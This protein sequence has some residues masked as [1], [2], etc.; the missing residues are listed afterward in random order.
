M[1]AKD[2]KPK[3]R[4]TVEQ[5]EARRL[6]AGLWSFVAPTEI[7]SHLTSFVRAEDYKLATLDATAIRNQ[8]ALAPADLTP[9]GATADNSIISV[10]RPDGTLERFSIFVSSIMAPEL[11]A[12]FPEIQTY[13]GQ[14]IDN[15]ASTIR[16]DMTPQGFHAQVISPGGTYYVDPFSNVPSDFY[17]VYSKGTTKIDTGF[18]ELESQ[19]GE[20]KGD[21]YSGSGT[22]SN[23][24]SIQSRS[25]THLRKY[26]LA[27][28]A[29]G[30]YTAFHG[31][32]V[33]LGQA[34]IVTAVN[35]V[36]E[37][38]Q[39]ELSITFQ[40]VANN[41]QLVFTNAGTDGYTNN[42]GGAMLG[43]NQT[44]LDSI[45][46]NSNY[47][48]GHVFSTGGGG[49][50]LLG[51]VG[52]N[53]VKA[54]GVTGLPAPIG[55]AFYVDYVAH[56]MGHQFGGNHTFNS[57]AGSCTGNRN[58]STA[59]EPG[60]GTTIQAYAGIC[61]GDDLQGNSD[62]YFHFASLD[63]FVA[64]VDKVIPNVG[65]R[66]ITGN[67]IPLINA[68][69]DY[70]I[71]ARTPFVLT[72]V[73]S[74]ADAFDSLTYD[75]QQSDL[76][77]TQPITAPDNGQSP[78]FR[79]WTPSASP[80]RTFP[81]LSDL[82]NNTTAKGERLPTTTRQL[83]F[84][85]V[86][87]DNRI[88]GGA[89]DDDSMRI[90][91][92]DTGA[93][94]AVVTP[95]TNVSWEGLTFQKVDWDV[96]GTTSNGINASSVNI[97]VSTDGGLSYPFAVA[98]G[99]ANNGSAIVRIPNAPTTKARVRV[100]AASNIFFDIS[101]VN[102]TIT[103]ATKVIDINLGPSVTFVENSNPI[104]V[105][106]A[107][108]VTETNVPGYAGGVLTLAITTGFQNGDILDVANQGSGAGEISINGS[109]VAFG[110]IVVGTY[111]GP[112]QSIKVTLNSAA[113]ASALQKLVARV[114]FVHTTDD[115]SPNARGVTAFLDNGVNGA[116][117]LATVVVNV[118][119]VNDSPRSGNASL[120]TINEDTKNPAGSSIAT[121]V[122]PSFQD[123][124]RGSSL[125]GIAITS[126][127]SSSTTGQWQYSIDAVA[128]LP[129]GNVTPA[130]GLA[131]S[132][133][134]LLRFLPSKDYF[135]KPGSLAYRAL[136]DTYLA[137]FSGVSLVVVDVTTAIDTGPISL[138]GA[139]LGI[140]IAPVNDAPITTVQAQKLSV[141][142]DA[143]L[144][145]PVPAG[146]F[147]DVDDTTLTLTLFPSN[148]A[149][150]PA[151][152][153]FDQKSKSL[154]GTP[155]N[156][157]VGVY[158]LVLKATDAAGLFT[159]LA[160]QLTVVNVNDAPT[161]IELVG[162]SV[163]ENE[164]GILIGIL[165]GTDKDRSDQLTWQVFDQR[166]VVQDNMLYLASGARLDYEAASHIDIQI[167][168]TDN[169]TPPLS[170]TLQKTIE[171]LDV[172]E[173]APSLKATLFNVSETALGGT[174]I[175]FL[176]ALDGDTNNKVQ[177]RFSGTPPTQFSLD[178]NTGRI[179]INAGTTLDHE[180]IASYQFFVE[181]AD[182]G[183]PSLATTASVNIT[184]ADVNE[185]APVITTE[186]IKMSERQVIA[187]PFAKVIASDRDTSQ[188]VQFFL[189]SS[190]TR[191]SINSSTG[192]LFL[193]RSGLFDF[194]THP[195]DLIVVIAQDTGTPIRRIEK[196][197][198]LLI[199]DANDPPT[200]AT[201]AN[202]NLLSNVTDMSLG[203]ISIADQDLG[204]KY[205]I[206][207][208]DDRFIVSGEDLIIAPGKFVGETDPLQMVVPVVVTE[209]G[210]DSKSY[211]LDVS[212]TRIPNKNPWQNR[213]NPL[214]V[215]REKGPD[216]L[217]A[218]AVINALN[219]GGVSRLPFPRPASTLSLPDYD[220]DGDGTINPLDVLAIINFLNTKASGE[221]ERD[222]LSS[223]L[224]RTEIDDASWLAAY[225]QIEEERQ[226][227]HLRGGSQGW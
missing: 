25:G 17:A 162:N 128:W 104:Q 151:W 200:A 64:H 45:I 58:A 112:G 225:T 11:A 179:S 197:I 224:S 207:S 41:D 132:S 140:Q 55:D 33:L 196:T 206:V 103:P 222:E 193:N 210:A 4:L 95:N 35:R 69:I 215:N 117:N 126:N 90:S 31:G 49:V 168:V 217:D 16:F 166:F 28:A 73:G 96:A 101:N 7:P 15:P 70:A 223:S 53:S 113:N 154:V 174:D 175:G 188:R 72:A 220:V 13:A 105:A 125:S 2:T 18:Q 77:P 155:S 44:K 180:T 163:R 107:A 218:L 102:F 205:T 93:P 92:V 80:S 137:G 160:L 212:L 8:L 133:S 57:D 187:V 122:G 121:L 191:F 208:S 67:N 131:L 176:V 157:E 227:R 194:E 29:T 100:Q 36:T 123:P 213:L 1:P 98:T 109:N 184:V 190:E 135:G 78:L 38:Y 40:L 84:R 156:E 150:L 201:V 177:Y 189:P 139:S 182:D 172:N 181:A 116:S 158:D 203:R 24:G 81:R 5:L 159:T 50:A 48:I 75:W 60:S 149:D 165:F 9:S 37:I 76:G 85:V 110:G 39:T 62:P 143:L 144:S 89:F 34:A 19:L 63:E 56:E 54:Q 22:S 47:D 178:N 136:D 71:P 169:G 147:T 82:V 134:T 91:V 199:Q 153:T 79:N 66:T 138:V 173:F 52:I 209:V 161:N 183:L 142:Q 42:N 12:K 114:T 202:P 3:K 185:Y 87:R 86:A 10:P 118:T 130:T 211:T 170:L 195:T 127:P 204:Q 43:E 216:P 6:L 167:R 106:P 94:F 148:S 97:S 83:N 108:K 129:I 219:S 120:A 186:T 14:G 141:N 198:P 20:F 214:D 88:T 99:V 61:G 124:D 27:V 146:W 46:G 226:H 145:F 68:G 59:Y 21:G 51:S 164:T 111:S 152:L 221:G 171:V 192:D 32:T 115:P 23:S 74:D 26:R 65:T 30:E 119:P